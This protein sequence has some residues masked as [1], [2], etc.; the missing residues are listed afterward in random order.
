MMLINL[1]PAT[2]KTHISIGMENKLVGIQPLSELVVRLWI[3]T[4]DSDQKQLSRFVP[5][6]KIYAERYLSSPFT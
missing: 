4:T 2:G 3:R 5:K 6:G 1:P